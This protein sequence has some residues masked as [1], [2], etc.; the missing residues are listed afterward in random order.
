ME[1]YQPRLATARSAVLWEGGYLQPGGH[2]RV[3]V[4][5]R[6]EVANTVDLP[7]LQNVTQTLSF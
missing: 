5:Y 4:N 1:F 3:I 7:V 6:L 2:D